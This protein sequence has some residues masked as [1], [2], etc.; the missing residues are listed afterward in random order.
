MLAFVAATALALAVAGVAGGATGSLTYKDCITGETESGPAGSDACVAIASA[1]GANSGLGGPSAVAVSPDGESLYALSGEDDA[2]AQFSRKTSN[3]KLTYEGCIT[4]EAATGPTGSD[5]CAAI[6]SATATGANSG[7]DSPLS[8]AVSSDGKAVYALGKGDDAVVHFKRKRS[9]GELTFEECLTGETASASACTTIPGATAAG[10]GAGLNDPQALALTGGAALYVV[11][12][13]DEAVVRLKRD[14]DTGELTYEDCV[15]G[16]TAAGPT[17][18]GACD[19]IPSATAAGT[20]SGLS[21][22]ID[23]AVSGDSV[24]VAGQGDTAIARFSRG[25]GGVLAYKNCITGETEAGPTGSGACDEIASA[26][27]GG[28]GS[29]LDSLR[30]V[31]ASKDGNSLYATGSS[32]DSVARFDRNKS[33]GKLTYRD[34][35]TAQDLDVCRTIPAAADGA[36]TGLDTAGDL[37]ISSDGA[38]VYVAAPF[39]DAVTV[40]ARNTSS[41]RLTHRS[42]ITGESATGPTGS[43]ACSE[44]PAAAENGTDSGLDNPQVIALSPDDSSLYLG[45]NADDSIARFSRA[46]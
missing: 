29:G 15:T 36:D 46:P 45:T 4:G 17:G 30:S 44:V 25:A 22:P 32:D 18:S 42:C 14:A 16:D 27:S 28:M 43:G 19:E 6:P 40:L 21:N 2:I 3:G 41:G 33:N 34:C 12:L 39:D 37:A 31:A 20:A 38:S 23:L 8:V 1:A 35:L 5:A 9:T 11:A 26:E 10:E 24:Y 7:M 13:G